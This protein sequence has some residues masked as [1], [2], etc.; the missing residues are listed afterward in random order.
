MEVATFAR[1]ILE[2]SQLEDK[3]HTPETLTDTK[4]QSESFTLVA[5]ARP[6]RL[7]FDDPRPRPRPPR[8]SALETPEARGCALHYFANHE[9]LAAELMA[10]CLLKFPEA[11]AAFRHGVQQTLLEEQQHLRRYLSRMQ[12]LGVAFGDIPVSGH[13]W[14]VLSQMRS[15]MD[16]VTGMSLVFEQANLDFAAQWAKHFEASDDPI[17]AQLM[18]DV[19]A[20]E[21]G[22]VKHG[23]IWFD[24][25][26]RQGDQF[27][28]FAESLPTEI[29]AIRARSSSG[30]M[31]IEARLK[32]GLSP[33]FINELR[34]HRGSRGRRPRLWV[35]WPDVED[36]MTGRYQPSRQL[37]KLTTDLA[38]V[39]GFLGSNDDIVISE[40]DYSPHVWIERLSAVGLPTPKVVKNLSL[41]Q[42]SRIDEVVPW[43]WSP[44]VHRRLQP[45][46]DMV[47]VPL[48]ACALHAD[49]LSKAS[50]GP[51]RER[52]YKKGWFAPEHFGTLMTSAV[53]VATHLRRHSDRQVVVKALYSASGRHRRIV[54]HPVS[55]PEM[56]W[57]QG[58][59]D[60]EG[61]VWVEAWLDKQADF[62]VVTTRDRPSPTML[63]L[64]NRRNGSYLGHILG[65]PDLGLPRELAAA[66]HRFRGGLRTL[67]QS[68]SELVREEFDLQTFGV[69]M[70]IERQPNGT[71]RLQPLVELNSRYTMGHIAR[72]LMS[73]IRSGHVGVFLLVHRTDLHASGL[74]NFKQLA[75]QWSPECTETVGLR[76]RRLVSGV[77]PLIHPDRAQIVMP[78]LAAGEHLTMV[79]KLLHPLDISLCTSNS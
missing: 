44:E 56:K 37:L 29:D 46:V 61:G 47:R 40:D 39:F 71:S 3:L 20:D 64:L 28:V 31:E 69:D 55:I 26:R 50:I 70:L 38:R 42:K 79:E 51:L 59:C 16:Y 52:A 4:P 49:Y 10:V 68:V 7:R 53:Q 27:N 74:H 58:Q 23:V 34:A 9:L 2:S 15:P 65:K 54:E 78:I 72:V 17:S 8:P 24:R 35:F 19:L 33:E 12:T 13:F 62:S 22:H 60:R 73:R 75:S 18:R 66:L 45:I 57:I 11:P 63:R 43:G 77:V 5:P 25:W 6:P 21:I 36:H 1:L 48:S 41:L 14:R 76:H 67:T 32:A 30:P